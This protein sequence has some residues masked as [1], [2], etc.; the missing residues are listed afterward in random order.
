MAEPQIQHA[1]T[2]IFWDWKS[3]GSAWSKEALDSDWPLYV[4]MMVD[5][6][7]QLCTVVYFSEY[8]TA[9]FIQITMQCDAVQG[10]TGQ[11]RTVQYSPA[12]YV[13]VW[14]SVLRFG[15]VP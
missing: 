2:K 15:R 3:V 7:E 8:S 10:R 1:N 6:S 12:P 4:I 11:C 14:C 13:T 9:N 5:I